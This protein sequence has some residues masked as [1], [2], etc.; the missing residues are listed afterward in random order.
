MYIPEGTDLTQT[1]KLIKSGGASGAWVSDAN[2]EGAADGSCMT[3]AVDA[4]AETCVPIQFTEISGTDI[5][6]AIQVEVWCARD[7]V[8]EQI[9]V[10]INNTSLGD[11][12]TK[13]IVSMPDSTNCSG[14]TIQTLGDLTSDVWGYSSPVGS[15]FNGTDL[16]LVL[17][18]MKVGKVGTLYVDAIQITIDHTA[19][20]SG[21]Q[22]NEKQLN[23]YLNR[24]LNQGLN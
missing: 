17:T 7:D 1:A 10:K 2:S 8:D 24:G 12:S 14:V 3:S 21:D 4:S 5:I 15:D 11:S 16:N 13:T 22:Y 23:K 18:H 9:D 6:N 19:A 20:P